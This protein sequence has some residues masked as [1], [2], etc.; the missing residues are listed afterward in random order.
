VIAVPRAVFRC[1]RRKK[2]AA[3][4]SV[5]FFSGAKNRDDRRPN[6][7]GSPA[8]SGVSDAIAIL[9]DKWNKD[10]DHGNCDEH[11]VLAVEAQKGKM[12]G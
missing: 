10:G 3:E 5:D 9:P 11:P 2:P 6:E 7:K 8:R 4:F 1:N 12:L